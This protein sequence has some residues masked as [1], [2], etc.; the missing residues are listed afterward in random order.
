MYPMI[1]NGNDF[2]YH[3]SAIKKCGSVENC[4][5][6]RLMSS[7]VYESCFWTA[8][9]SYILVDGCINDKNE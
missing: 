6:Q 7:L 3:Q 9:G 5:V 8:L 1:K 2:F 4:W